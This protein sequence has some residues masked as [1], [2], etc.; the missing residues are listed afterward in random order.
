MIAQQNGFKMAY[1]LFTVYV[2]FLW[3]QTL[4]FIGHL[5]LQT[6]VTDRGVCGLKEGACND[7]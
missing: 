6:L 1:S 5:Q 7:G 2:I 4:M 3:D